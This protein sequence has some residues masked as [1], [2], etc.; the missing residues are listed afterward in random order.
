MSCGIDTIGT[1]AYSSQDSYIVCYGLGYEGYIVALHAAGGVHVETV[2]YNNRI[3]IPGR[4]QPITTTSDNDTSLAHLTLVSL[5]SF[6]LRRAIFEQ[7]SLEDLLKRNL[8]SRHF[9]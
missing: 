1:C 6:L 5:R 8:A 7:S 3:H 4:W 2:G 9:I